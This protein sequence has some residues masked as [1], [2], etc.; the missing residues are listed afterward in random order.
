MSYV[1][2]NTNSMVNGEIS[3]FTCYRANCSDCVFCHTGPFRF[4]AAISAKSLDQEMIEVEELAKELEAKLMKQQWKEPSERSK[5]SKEARRRLKWATIL[6]EWA[7][8]YVKSQSIAARLMPREVPVW[9]APTKNNFALLS[10]E[11]NV[12]E[13]FVNDDVLVVPE[14]KKVSKKFRVPI[15]WKPVADEDA[16]L[17]SKVVDGV[18]QT[19]LKDGIWRRAVVKGAQKMKDLPFEERCHCMMCEKNPDRPLVF[20]FNWVTAY[21]WN[22]LNDIYVRAGDNMCRMT[23]D[24]DTYLAFMHDEAW[25]EYGPDGLHYDSPIHMMSCC[26][27]PM[28][29]LKP[30]SVSP[31]RE[32]VCHACELAW[33]NREIEWN[34]MNRILNC[35]PQEISEVTCRQIRYTRQCE[36]VV[37]CPKCRKCIYHCKC[38]L[39]FG[40]YFVTPQDVDYCDSLEKAAEQFDEDLKRNLPRGCVHG[41][42]N[43]D[44]MCVGDKGPLFS[45]DECNQF[46]GDMKVWPNY[47]LQSGDNVRMPP[48]NYADIPR[49]N[50]E[51]WRKSF[52]WYDARE[53]ERRKLVSEIR[54]K[55]QLKHG[56]MAKMLK[57]LE[58]VEAELQIGFDFNMF[59]N[60]ND[61][62]VKHILEIPL[63]SQFIDMMKE[64]RSDLNWITVVKE[65]L[66]FFFVN[67]Q[68][69]F[70]KTSISVSLAYLL[71]NLPLGALADKFAEL[72]SCP[73]QSGVEEGL[74]ATVA[75]IVTVLATLAVGAFPSSKEITNFM[76]RLSRL[77]QCLRSIDEVQAR[78]PKLIKECIRYFRKTVY[79]VEEEELDAFREMKEWIGEIQALNTTGFEARAKDDITLK[80]VVD[81]LIARG[82][83]IGK[84]LDSL[85]IPAYE[86]RE[87]N[88]S[89]MLL[90]E[91][92][93]TVALRNAG[94]TRARAAPV[95]VHLFGNT[96]C[97]KSTIVSS[98]CAVSLVHL[99]HSD[100][101]SLHDLVY[102]NYPVESGF[103]DGYRNGTE[104]IV[105]DDAFTRK[106]SEANPNPEIQDIIR[107]CNVSFYW[108]NM[109]DLRDKGTTLCEPS[110]VLLTSNRPD[111]AMD[112]VTNKEAVIRR[113]DLKF[114]QVPKPQFAKEVTIMNTQ[115]IV[116]DQEKAQ[117]HARVSPNGLRDCVLFNQVDPHNP[118]GR[119]IRSALSFD[120]V[121]GMVRRELTRAREVGALIN[122]DQ[123][124]YF[125]KLVDAKRV[126]EKKSYAEVVKEEKKVESTVSPPPQVEN[127]APGC[128][129][130]TDNEAEAVQ[131]M[132]E[133]WTED[134]ESQ[135][136]PLVYTDEYQNAKPEKIVKDTNYKI[137]KLLSDDEMAKRSGFGQWQNLP[138]PDLSKFA[139]TEEEKFAWDRIS[140]IPEEADGSLK[141]FHTNNV[142]LRYFM[143]GSYS[144]HLDVWG[145][146]VHANIPLVDTSFVD[147]AWEIPEDSSFLM[148]VRCLR[149]PPWCVRDFL[150][151][152]KTAVT[153]ARACEVQYMKNVFNQIMLRYWKLNFQTWNHIVHQSD[154]DSRAVCCYSE[155]HY[156][157]NAIC[158]FLSVLSQSKPSFMQRVGTY[159]KST[160]ER[161]SWLLP[162]AVCAAALLLFNYG[163]SKLISR[164]SGE[165]IE[166]P[167]LPPD[168]QIGCV[169][170]KKLMRMVAPDYMRFVDICYATEAWTKPQRV[171]AEEWSW[172][173]QYQPWFLPYCEDD[174]IKTL[175]RHPKTKEEAKR[176]KEVKKLRDF[177]KSRNIAYPPTPANEEGYGQARDGATPVVKTEAYGQQKD[178]ATPVV[179][180]EAYGQAKDAARPVVRTEMAEATLQ[181]SSDQNASEIRERVCR[182]QYQ[183]SVGN[184]TIGWRFLGT[185]TVIRGRVAIFNRHFI[186]AMEAEDEIRIISPRFNVVYKFPT[187]AL[188]YAVFPDKAKHGK[189]DVAICELPAQVHIHG[190]LMK[191]VMTSEDFSRHSMLDMVAVTGVGKAGT[192]ECYVCPDVAARDVLS[193][194]INGD[195]WLLRQAYTYNAPTQNGDCGRILVAYDKRFERKI[196]GMHIAGSDRGEYTAIGIAISHELLTTLFGCLSLRKP[197]SWC[198]GTVNVDI[199]LECKFHN[200]TDVELPRPLPG[201]FY[202]LGK[203][204]TPVHQNSKTQIRPSPL[205]GEIAE[206]TTKPAYLKRCLNEKGVVI[207]PLATAMLKAKTP[208]IY[209]DP[210][211]IEQAQNNYREKLFKRVDPADAL[212]LS[213]EEAITGVEGNEW[214]PPINRKTSPG[215]GWPTSGSGKRPY[216][217]K[218]EYKFDHPEVLSRYDDALTQ[219]ESGRRIGVFWSD[220]LK[221]ERR[222]IQKV[223]DGK[224]RLFAAGEMVFTIIFRR[225]F[226]GYAAHMARNRIRVESCVGIN[227]HGLDWNDLA[228]YLQEV[229]EHVIAGDFTNYD[230][231]LAAAILWAV[232]EDIEE[233]YRRYDPNWRESHASFR[234]L[235]W[236]DIVNSVHVLEHIVWIWF[237]SQPSGC[238]ITSVLN[239]HFKSLALR[240][241]YKKCAFKYAP[242]LA[243]LSNFTRYVRLAGFGD[244]D[245][246]NIHPDIIDW[247]NQITVS[248]AYTSLGMTYTD[249]N[250]SG[251]LVKSRK[252]SEVS[253]LKR[254][255]LFDFSKGIYRA[256]LALATILEMAM[257]VSKG[258]KWAL[259]ADTLEQAVEEL[260]HHA[261]TV[262]QEW[263]PKFKQAQDKI[264]PHHPCTLNTYEEYQQ[265]FT[266]RCFEE[267]QKLCD[268]DTRYIGVTPRVANLARVAPQIAMEESLGD[269]LRSHD[270]QAPDKSALLTNKLA[271]RHATFQSGSSDAPRSRPT[272][273]ATPM[274]E[275]G[276]NEAPLAA[277]P[278]TVVDVQQIT[279]FNEDGPVAEES[280]VTPTTAPRKFLKDAED[281]LANDVKGFLSR[282][283]EMK[284]FT[285][286]SSTGA[287]NTLFTLDLPSEWLQVQ[288]IQEKLQGFRY[289]RCDF[290]IKI[291]VN[292]QAFNAGRL[293]GVF[294]PLFSQNNF[295]PSSTY[296]LQGLTGYRR[297]DLDLATSTAVE[298]RVP[299]FGVISHYDLILALGTAGRVFGE[300]YSP[301]TGST[302]VEGTVWCW[303]ENIDITMPTSVPLTF[304]TGVAKSD[305][306]L[307]RFHLQVGDNSRSKPSGNAERK[308]PG[309]IE[310]IA[311]STGQV[312]KTLGKIP[313]IGGAFSDAAWISDGVEM[314][315][316]TFG[317]SKPN[318][319]EFTQSM[320]PH[321]MSDM[322]NFDGDARAKQFGF[323]SRNEVD[324]PKDVFGTEEDEM[325]LATI[326]AHPTF[327]D[328]FTM[329]GAQTTNTLLWK[330]PVDP[331]SCKKAAYT[332]AAKTGVVA[333]NTY[334]S[335]LSNIALFWRGAIK[336]HFKIVKTPFHSGRIRVFFAPGATL[337]TDFATLDVNKMYSKVYD[338][339]ETNE[340]DFEVPFTWN[341]PWKCFNG[342]S[343]I[344]PLATTA[345]TDQL[346][347]GMIYVS[348]VN[349]LLNPTTAASQIEFLVE[350]SAGEDFQFA[351]PGLRDKFFRV[352]DR[353]NNIPA[354]T[355]TATLQMGDKIYEGATLPGVDANALAIGE[356]FTSLR[357][358]MKRYTDAF[359][360]FLASGEVDPFVFSSISQASHPDLDYLDAVPQ[361]I[362][363]FIEALYRFYSGSMRVMTITSENDDN[364]VSRVVLKPGYTIYTAGDITLSG[365]KGAGL[366]EHCWSHELEPA[367]E[368]EVPFYQP[369]PALPTNVGVPAA[370]D[371]QTIGAV[372]SRVPSLPGSQLQFTAP[373]SAGTRVYTAIGEKFSFGYLL[374]PPTTIQ[375]TN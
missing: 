193:L 94:S 271:I 15:T 316:H 207:D 146:L 309:T 375:F 196:C 225:F 343:G 239:S 197:E 108:L 311:H 334:L 266:A 344:P 120:E 6:N 158:Q 200:G 365:L 303:A 43:S 194:K 362:H 306:H 186:P 374:G 55:C 359:Q 227:P 172:V 39:S 150:S 218:E 53:S 247:F 102:Y 226:A 20:N 199:P 237:H 240:I 145:S 257:W 169:L 17:T 36:R 345:L 304:P 121:A 233:F 8:M 325:A 202:P 189:K 318:N 230:G 219:L 255:F 300:V 50:V 171:S 149:I 244:D 301:L 254:A 54:R 38:V 12:K 82:Q 65:L 140:F 185:M 69:G 314:L 259:T 273:Q 213:F 167:F 279:T 68:S 162:A 272:E 130:W 3:E 198:D 236:L 113:I 355:A 270:S 86:R 173:S 360:S 302:D 32:N 250:K 336:Y 228:W 188:N 352:I 152:F 317:F 232:L 210:L 21:T 33:L 251:E 81:D 18:H 338:L 30:D 37:D 75:T 278:M 206:V 295:Q 282:P 179:R 347:Q 98:L 243:P 127:P 136:G 134:W 153:S 175:M 235:I 319:P 35:E 324:I 184:D 168:L 248:E 333:F 170:V 176:L 264:L 47:Y 111:P 339:R 63:V 335:Y 29:Y 315:A 80:Q 327:M 14:P 92:R 151:Y 357:Q 67:Y 258:D 353:A 22:E 114:Q 281:S 205:H 187:S 137:H 346:P 138:K 246:T 83:E 215:H 42:K 161:W 320:A 117:A 48:L 221:D 88:E 93:R 329:T 367:A 66:Y 58:P 217:G 253:F 294:E 165:R 56:E 340:F 195:A 293:I 126:P 350:T 26:N 265:L 122:D 9:E 154:W 313:I 90:R 71:S 155:E 164:V 4:D 10:E 354:P 178:G 7:G 19:W 292:A 312:V 260:A 307:Q 191:Y 148:K 223:E 97:G 249:E 222:P 23:W 51:V 192:L 52:K 147:P 234:R 211:L 190:D 368:F 141:F 174:Q 216:L 166:M 49:E 123:K 328:Y 331:T 160:F 16:P 267:G 366:P 61:F 242:T 124:D 291:Q 349:K 289:L 5:I 212:V 142:F 203:T 115:M 132:T 133:Q 46:A 283:V 62:K 308:R 369:Y 163:S 201:G 91:M 326:M 99:G 25:K 110:L 118:N 143:P 299:F 276:T 341:A 268:R 72:I 119:V 241:V 229:G 286:A 182:N 310:T 177:C 144:D 34:L 284:N 104:I 78:M 214:I 348:V 59:H 342:V 45:V 181:G 321:I 372:Y 209:V 60:L 74:A 44:P 208:E 85:K 77:G 204:K 290:V 112:S 31:T 287:L 2:P 298:F 245:V 262:F 100:P 96:G 285:W 337:A 79:G 269:L 183:L 73:L 131:K 28:A 106:D 351:Y 373:M 274:S 135:V 252:I 297:V 363:G 330:W 280:R 27:L 70:T 103:K 139:R 296:S 371:Y 361:H 128:S 322:A 261:Q 180:T 116:L 107:F 13:Y 87:F 125:K 275:P 105:M 238:P 256:P 57:S 288:M 24:Y 109:A 11:P 129:D 358:L 95:A 64:K 224:T 41:C 277:N 1:N 364:L 159:I 332:G 323:S 305:R 220:T 231:T 157:E 76:T 89:S 263:I 101:S 40:K 370:A 84:F 356:Q 156:N